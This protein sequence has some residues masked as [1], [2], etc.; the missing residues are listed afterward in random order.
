MRLFSAA[1]PEQRAILDRPY[2][3]SA[4]AA[5]LLS[6]TGVKFADNVISYGLAGRLYLS[7]SGWLLLQVPNAIGRGAFDAL[8]EQGVELPTRDTNDPNEVFN[9]HISVMSK[10]EVDSIGV[11]KISE[12]GHTFHYTLGPVR[13]ITPKTWDGVSKVWAIECYSPE[14]KNLRKSY[15]LNPLPGPNGDYQFHITF[16]IRRTNALRQAKAA[17]AEADGGYTAESGERCQHCNAL[18]ERGDDNKCN[19]CGKD[20]DHPAY[21]S[22]RRLVALRVRR[23]E[24]IA[25]GIVLDVNRVADTCPDCMSQKRAN[26]DMLA[27]K[28][29]KATGLSNEEADRKAGEGLELPRKGSF[30]EHKR[31]EPVCPHCDQE[32]GEKGY[33]RDRDAGDNMW[34][35]GA[36]YDKGPFELQHPD[37]ARMDAEAAAF[38]KRWNLDKEAGINEDIDAAAAECEEPKSKE[39]AEAGNYRHGHCRLHG[40]GITIETGK[41]MTRKGTSKSGKAWSIALKNSYGYIK[42]TLS[43]AD[44]D[45]ID[46]FLN[47][48]D[49]EHE[50]AFIVDQVDP[51]TGN[52]DEHKV[53]LFFPTKEAAKQA[54]LDNYSAGWQ[55]FSGITAITLPDFKEWIKNGD[56]SKPYA[57][58][59]RAAR[60]D[61]QAGVRDLARNENA[62]QLPQRHELQGLRREGDTCLSK[63]AAELCRVLAGYGSVSAGS[64]ARSSE[65]SQTLHP[66]KLPLGNTST[67]GQES[68]NKSAAHVSGPNENPDRVGGNLQSAGQY[69][70]DAIVSPSLVTGKIA[71]NGGWHQ[72]QGGTSQTHTGRQNSIDR[73]VGARTG[74]GRGNSEPSIETGLVHTKNAANAKTAAVQLRDRLPVTDCAPDFQKIA[75][76]IATMVNRATIRRLLLGAADRNW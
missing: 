19:S 41:G 3:D 59:T 51:A 39:Q 4:H 9:A 68:Q 12:R 15:G 58:Q 49:A 48:G 40:M 21:A 42:R 70:L 45:H 75:S 63:V 5:V 57:P 73:S 69:A 62:M 71:D 20:H 22:H 54:Y 33:S 53:M 16:A 47:D 60:N 46:V 10:K 43:E 7:K 14:L 64:H 31:Y 30:K 17:A 35:H 29:W 27:F 76:P 23:G 55:G 26:G 67:T 28:A 44:G 18:H 74:A 56:T 32:M 37:Q 65:L 11:D 13:E 1:T 8:Y 72:K 24:C 52:F 61:K 38:C 34:R 36:C 50:L 2:Y 66:D 6:L 25:C